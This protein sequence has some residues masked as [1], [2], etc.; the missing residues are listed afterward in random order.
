MD[1]LFKLYSLLF[2]IY[3]L[4]G[5]IAII[6]ISI[7]NILAPR[8]IE[9][10]KFTRM[11]PIPAKIRVWEK[12]KSII[13][14][15]GGLAKSGPCISPS[16]YEHFP[17]LVKENEIRIRENSK[18]E[19]SGTFYEYFIGKVPGRVQAKAVRNYPESVT[20]DLGEKGYHNIEI[21]I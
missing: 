16:S 17:E 2:K 12:S 11:Y 9:R 21:K 13:E 4:L 1:S 18:L 19:V 8:E 5:I 7:H 6:F 14:F 10:G 20:N 3:S 15:K